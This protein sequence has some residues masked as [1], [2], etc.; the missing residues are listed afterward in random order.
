MSSDQDFSAFLAANGFAARP[1]L[2][3]FDGIMGNKVEVFSNE[4]LLLRRVTDRGRRYIDFSRSGA[5]W[6]DV[7]TLIERIDPSFRP[8]TGSFDEAVRTL[9]KHWPAIAVPLP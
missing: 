1:E 8:K 6:L 4:D 7:F 2:S 3:I 9:V 5:D